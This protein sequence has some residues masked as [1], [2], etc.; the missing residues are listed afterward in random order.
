MM[1]RASFAR[2]VLSAVLLALSAAP[3]AWCQTADS[4]G[5]RASLTVR[6]HADAT[7]TVDDRPTRQEGEVR[8][9][10][11]PP[12][13]PGKSYH[14][15]LVARWN[16]RYDYE[17]Y[18]ARRVVHVEAGKS[19][20]VD[21]RVLRPEKGDTIEIIYVPTPQ[22]TVDAMMKLAGVGKDDVV[23]DLGC[24]DG[25]IVI[26]AV[27]NFHAQR[28]VGVD[29]E[30]DRI[31]EAKKNA[32]QAEV[33]D[34]VEFRK[35][36]VFQVKDIA[37]ATVVTLYLSD[38]LNEKLRQTLFKQLRPGTRIVSHRF[39]MG[40]WKPEKTEMVDVEDDIPEEKLIHL[41]T[42]PKK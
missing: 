10:H 38:D 14:Y 20:E 4:A 24:G 40:D 22:K 5:Q 28:G 23:F 29:L 37:Q 13:E 31:K 1:P 16:P 41:W 39:T 35:G 18:I 26:T 17:T 19:V 30:T 25:R 2:S 7:L 34:R 9:F 32:R 12:L 42:I 6:L 3:A 11:S 27:K 33:E 8:R 36:D 15:T 21:L